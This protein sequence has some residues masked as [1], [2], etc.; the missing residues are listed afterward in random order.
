MTWRPILERLRPRGGRAAS[1]A[2]VRAGS[3]VPAAGDVLEL[4][5]GLQQPPLPGA[6][7]A[8]RVEAVDGR[9]VWF[10]ALPESDL[11]VP[12]LGGDRWGW[13]PGELWRA[14]A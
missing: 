12:L 11:P 10:V 3:P 4:A 6:P 8:L 14:R 2:V 7:G 1:S 5:G 13:R 9:T